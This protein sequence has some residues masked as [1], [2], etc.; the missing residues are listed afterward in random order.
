VTGL[1]DGVALNCVQLVCSFSGLEEVI[2]DIG[3]TLYF[4]GFD[5]GSD[6]YLR[7]SG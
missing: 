3:K 5:F 1:S 7:C 2:F 4:G 6:I